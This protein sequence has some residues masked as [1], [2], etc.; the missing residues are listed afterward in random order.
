MEKVDLPLL[1]GEA[2]ATFWPRAEAG[3]VTL[4]MD[5][6]P[7]L[8]E[9]KASPPHVR[10][11]ID[12]LLDNALKYSSSGGLVT[13][14][15]RPANE[16]VIVSVTDTGQGI[17]SKDLPHV[18][19]RFY[20]SDRSRSR[21]SAEEGTGGLGLAIVRSI[22]NAHGGQVSIDSQEGKGTTVRITLPVYQD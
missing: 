8:P 4:T 22:V 6:A 7:Q 20:R 18:F 11:V 1:L 19:E 5:A 14:S 2:M 13:V 9:V 16:Q 12:N 10:Q 21:A 17:P 3:G 15:C